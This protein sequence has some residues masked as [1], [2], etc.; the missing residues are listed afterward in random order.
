MA[1]LFSEHAIVKLSSNLKSRRYR[2]LRCLARA[3]VAR[4]LKKFLT[5]F[6]PVEGTKPPWKRKEAR[7]RLQ[8]VHVR[9]IRRDLFSI[10]SPAITQEDEQY[11]WCNERL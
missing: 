9:L 7:E 5:M 2:L 11:G 3:T 8:M 4:S 6:E 10:A 1:G